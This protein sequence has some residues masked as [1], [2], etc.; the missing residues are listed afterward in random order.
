MAV[1]LQAWACPSVFGQ[2][3]LGY[4]LHAGTQSCRLSLCPRLSAFRSSVTPQALPLGSCLK[5]KAIGC[6]AMDKCSGGRQPDTNQNLKAGWLPSKNEGLGP[7]TTI[8]DSQ[9]E[10][11]EPP[12]HSQRWLSSCP[13]CLARSTDSCAGGSSKA[14]SHEL[15]GGWVP[16]PTIHGFGMCS[17]GWLASVPQL[18][19]ACAAACSW[20]FKARQIPSR[21]FI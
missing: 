15:M 17:L 4:T 20:P 1:L 18:T 12:G 13:C 8:A 14:P 3:H 6:R 11:W 16:D 10:P 19:I 7:Q 2:P 9:W 21:A 5:G